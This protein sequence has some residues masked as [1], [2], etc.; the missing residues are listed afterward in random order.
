M[1]SAL[2]RSRSG[3]AVGRQNRERARIRDA[4]YVLEF[5]RFLLTTLVASVRPRHDLFVENL[6][7]RINWR[8]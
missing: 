6:L 3:A 8:C 2:G 4:E 1:R 7:L 5:L